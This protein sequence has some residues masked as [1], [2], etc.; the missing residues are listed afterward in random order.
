MEES[1]DIIEIRDCII[2]LDAAT[3]ILVDGKVIPCHQKLLGIRQKLVAIYKTQC[4]KNGK[5]STILTEENESH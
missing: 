5:D 3:R 4:E 2:K 1:K